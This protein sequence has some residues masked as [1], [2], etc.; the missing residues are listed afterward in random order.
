[1]SKKNLSDLS[2]TELEERLF[3]TDEVDELYRLQ[4]EIGRRVSDIHLKIFDEVSER[5]KIIL[6]KDL[7]LLDNMQDVCLK[8]QDSLKEDNNAFN[9]R[10]R[11]AARELLRPDNY[12]QIARAAEA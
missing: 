8:R 3:T 5:Q 12:N 4:L 11:Q 9:K 2:L 7:S 6:K 1:M 10:F